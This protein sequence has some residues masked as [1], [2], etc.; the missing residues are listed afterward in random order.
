M[1][2]YIEKRGSEQVS[3][4]KKGGGRSESHA[5]FSEC[6]LP[7]SANIHGATGAFGG[8]PVALLIIT[9]C[10]SVVRGEFVN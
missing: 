5:Y 4:V 3:E 8:P 6:C 9:T 1:Y 7:A 10:F 2:M